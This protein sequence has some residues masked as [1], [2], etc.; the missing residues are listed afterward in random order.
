MAGNHCLDISP[1]NEFTCVKFPDLDKMEKIELCL[2]HK[3]AGVILGD[4]RNDRTVGKYSAINLA[5]S[6]LLG[7]TD[8]VPY[9]V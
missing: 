1:V 8:A 2:S 3:L 7:I 5:A 6:L 9:R 4:L